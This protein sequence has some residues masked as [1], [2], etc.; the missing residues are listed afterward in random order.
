MGRWHRL[1]DYQHKRRHSGT[2]VG[3]DDFKK[4]K[5][6]TVRIL[7]SRITT[8]FR[9]ARAGNKILVTNGGKLCLTFGTLTFSFVGVAQHRGGTE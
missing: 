6:R 4:R 5:G 9:N 3:M 8:V 7:N 1:S 2:R